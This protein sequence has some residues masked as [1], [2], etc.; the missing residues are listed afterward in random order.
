M[1]VLEYTQNKINIAERLGL[2]STVYVMLQQEI[3]AL[4]TKE[5][6]TQIK[7][8]D[9]ILPTYIHTTRQQHQ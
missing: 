7:V 5:Q 2:T 4:I 6:L 3:V 1:A 9:V 8:F